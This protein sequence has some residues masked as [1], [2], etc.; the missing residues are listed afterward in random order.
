MTIVDIR[1]QR[2]CGIEGP[3]QFS[4]SMEQFGGK[5]TSKHP[6]KGQPCYLSSPTPEG[7]PQSKSS[8]FVIFSMLEDLDLT[9][10]GLWRK[11]VIIGPTPPPGGRHI[12]HIDMFSA[13]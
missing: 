9:K 1:S 2:H 11:H 7:G 3:I 6:S 10:G 8:T 4:P 5:F 13:S 12:G